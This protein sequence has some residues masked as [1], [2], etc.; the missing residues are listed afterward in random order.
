MVEA[1]VFTV[2]LEHRTIISSSVC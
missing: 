2:L 1:T